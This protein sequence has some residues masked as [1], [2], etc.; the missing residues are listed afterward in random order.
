MGRQARD[1]GLGPGPDCA[2]GR[3]RRPWTLM[4]STSTRNPKRLTRADRDRA[5]EAAASANATMD[6]R[7]AAT[8]TLVVVGVVAFAFVA[9]VLVPG[10]G[11]FGGPLQPDRL[12]G[13]STMSVID[14]TKG[15][16]VTLGVPV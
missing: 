16:S 3:L 8:T 13:G 6:L 5:R 2:A 15:K 10:G 14:K 4:P 12:E 1:G 11:S 9:G 7:P